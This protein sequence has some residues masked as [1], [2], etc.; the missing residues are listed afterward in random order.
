MVQ[1]LGNGAAD[2]NGDG[3]VSL[4]ELAQW[5]APRVSRDAKQANRDQTPSLVVGKSLGPADGFIVE[6]GLAAK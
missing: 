4:A 5:V 2:I 1:G 3:Q 6:W